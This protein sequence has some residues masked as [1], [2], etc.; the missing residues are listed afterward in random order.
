M[1]ATGN[2]AL[3]PE[4]WVMETHLQVISNITML[5]IPHAIDGTTVAETTAPNKYGVKKKRETEKDDNKAGKDKNRRPIKI[6]APS[7]RFS[8]NHTSRNR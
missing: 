5:G 1:E 4:W 7:E 3:I 8:R 2:D 6:Q